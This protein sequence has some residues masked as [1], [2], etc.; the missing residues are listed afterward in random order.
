MC[1]QCGCNQVE[2]THGLKTIRDSSNVQMPA[3]ISIAQMVEP[4]ETP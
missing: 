2:N 4:T 3:N 1:L